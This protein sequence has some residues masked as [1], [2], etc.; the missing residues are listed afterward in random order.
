MAC[1]WQVRA[2]GRGRQRRR[3]AAAARAPAE[4]FTALL[5]AIDVPITALRAA[6]AMAI[7]EFFTQGNAIYLVALQQR[8]QC[9][10]QPKRHIPRT[11]VA[12]NIFAKCMHIATIVA[13]AAL[14]LKDAFFVLAFQVV[15]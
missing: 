1:R 7:L 11:L 8:C 4:A 10:R 2:K 5:L 9:S 3:G 6:R 14:I 12:I 13:M 15:F